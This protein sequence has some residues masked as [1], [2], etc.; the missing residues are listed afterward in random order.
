MDPSTLAT[1]ATA[2]LKWR[3]CGSS[4]SRFLV[5]DRGTV[6][7]LVGSFVSDSISFDERG[8]HCQYSTPPKPMAQKGG[9]STRLR[10]GPRLGMFI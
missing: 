6:V 9:M 8:R 5:S 2:P 3:S 10:T 4:V 1:D 7:P